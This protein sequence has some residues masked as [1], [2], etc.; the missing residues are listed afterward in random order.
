M[1]KTTYQIGYK[2]KPPTAGEGKYD[3]KNSGFI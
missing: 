1:S 3:N 2:Y